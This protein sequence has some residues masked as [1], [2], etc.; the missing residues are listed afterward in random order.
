MRN[1]KSLNHKH[2]QLARLL[3]GGHSQ[4][5]I[6]KLLNLNKSTICRLTHDPLIAKEVCRLQEI[7]DSNSMVCVPGI[8]EKISDGAYKGI[9]ILESIL[10]DERKDVDILKLKANISL[11]LLNR[12]GYGPVKQLQIKQESINTVLSVDDIEKIK[13]RANDMMRKII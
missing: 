7:A 9:E 1:L 12:A 5:E 2:Q 6:S 4:A 11:E 8:T 10:S 13:I 3:V